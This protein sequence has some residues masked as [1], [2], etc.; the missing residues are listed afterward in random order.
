[1]RH[2]LVPKRRLERAKVVERNTRETR[3]Q[4]P[5]ALAE[6]R[7][8]RRRERAESQPVETVLA[9]DNLRPPGRRAPELQRR[10]DG[11]GARAREEHASKRRRR[12]FEQLAR[13]Q[14]RQRRDAQLYLPRRLQLER[15][16]DRRPDPRVVASNV[17]HPETAEQVEIAPPVGVVEVRALGPRPAAV[18]ADRLQQADELR[19][20]G[21]GVEL[22]L[23]ALALVEQLAQGHALGVDPLTR[24]SQA[25]TLAAR[26]NGEDLGE[27][28]YSRL[29]RRSGAEVE[30]RRPVEPLELLLRNACL[31]QLLSP[32][33]LGPAGSERA[34]VERVAGERAG[35][36]RHVPAILVREHDDRCPVVGLE[37]LQHLLGPGNEEFVCAGDPLWRREPGACVSDDRAPA[38]AFR[39]P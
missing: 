22:E 24:R 9:G 13:E 18:E 23:L 35:Q 12:A 36:R 30:A 3:Q 10:F 14:A 34:D 25:T 21:P 16:D 5:E 37:L 27:D 7:V 28:R 38:E 31:E 33:L 19:V 15:L 29:R 11:L 17:V 1:D 32:T 4:G 39:R 8:A 20:D 2:V 6:G 26:A